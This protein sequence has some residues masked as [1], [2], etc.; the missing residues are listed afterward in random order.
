MAGVMG[1][2]GLTQVGFIVKDIQKTK[3]KFAELFGVPAPAH[4]DGGKFE[5][6]GAQ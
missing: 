2:N 4:F 5:A 1:N 3:E 6:T